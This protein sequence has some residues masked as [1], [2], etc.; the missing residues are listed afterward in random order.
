MK[1]YR[2]SDYAI[3]KNAK[4]IVY[5]FADQTVEITLADYLRENP[6]KTAADFEALK[7]LSDAD[8]YETD[9]SGYR[10]SW[11][12]TSLDKLADDKN[13]AFTVPSAEDEVIL[14]A[15]QAAAYA[16]RKSS[17][18][19]VLDKLTDVQRRR[20]LMYHV[21]GLSTY[22]IAEREG[23]NQKSVHESLQ[24]AEKKIKKYLSKG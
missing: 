17:A 21:Q 16:K 15:E 22:Q 14:Q 3:N 4:G 10:Q 7:A 5:R 18:V 23:T 11:K 9:R 2:D 13:D 1:N 20:Y 6:A 8:Y 19:L 12:N 24:A